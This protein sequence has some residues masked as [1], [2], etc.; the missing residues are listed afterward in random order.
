[1]RKRIVSWIAALALCLSLLPTAAWAADSFT[2]TANNTP[3]TATANS[4]DYTSEYKITEE[5]AAVSVSGSTAKG[6]ILVEASNVT[7]TLDNVSMVLSDCNGSPIE[8]AADK[9]ATL[10]LKGT[11][12]LT[13]HAAGPGI[14]VNQGA[15]LTIRAD[16]SDADASL[17]VHGAQMDQYTDSGGGITGGMM[18]G[19]AGIGGP[20]S[21]NSPLTY[22]GAINIESGTINATGYGYGAGIG[23]GDYSSGGTIHISGGKVTAICGGTDPDGW[24]S[25]THKQGSGIGASQGQASGTITISGDAVVAAYGGYA[26]AGIGGGTADVTIKDTA[27]VTAYGGTNAAG[28]GGYNQNKGDS[29]ITISDTADVTAYGGQ[30]ASGIGQGSAVSAVTLSLASTASVIAYSDGTK[31][32]IT[33]TPSNDSASIINLYMKN[34]TL[35]SMNIPL[36]LS[37]GE[38]VKQTVTLAA[39][40]KAVGTTCE[41]GDYAVSANLGQGGSYRLIPSEGTSFDVTAG[42][43]SAA[44]SGTQTV[45]LGITDNGATVQLN[46]PSGTTIFSGSG[47][48]LEFDNANGTI[49]V[50][51]GGSV[52][53]TTWPNGGTVSKSGVLSP[54]LDETF[55]FE[56]DLNA[57]EEVVLGQDLTLSVTVAP[58]ADG[59][60]LTYQWYKDGAAIQGETGASL[61]LAD[62]S[63]GDLGAYH[64]VVTKTLNGKTATLT[65][66]SCVVSTI[67]VTGITLDRSSLTLTP[68]ERAALTASLLPADAAN[69][70]I[71]WESSDE[72]VAAVD[73]NGVVSAIAAGTAIITVTTEDGGFT[74]QCEITVK[75]P[76]IPPV[77][78]S[79]PP[80]RDPEVPEEPGETGWTNPFTDVAEGAWY[81]DPVR[82]SCENGLMSGYG[83]GRFGPD[84]ILSRAQ[85]AQ[86][87]YDL[88]G[89]PAVAYTNS[90]TDVAADAWYAGAVAW[91]SASGIVDGYG[92]GRFGPN[93]PVTRE[94]LAAMLYRYA[95]TPAVGVS[96][97]ALLGRF[98]DGEAVGGWAREAVAWAVAGGLISGTDGGAL[99]P[100]GGATRAQAATILM[101]FAENWDK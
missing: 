99:A 79:V 42:A 63:E 86:I 25:S 41:A 55:A 87:L 8:I 45:L 7:V 19:F 66:Q 4:T 1:M 48:A 10:V 72:T 81:Y 47:D 17:T 68:Q 30:S 20:N 80:E 18:T 32:A 56:R 96:E 16:G 64:V 33:G 85:L 6:R 65:S 5:N 26:C 57:S 29:T 83:D 37:T 97:L 40:Y 95:G 3:V 36:T 34:V 70:N 100:R 67:R 50:P 82:Y 27:K 88:E 77:T 28:I 35:P 13:A 75:A 74:A 9:S 62:I 91:A 53:E 58:P 22:T 44:Y 69:Q 60:T 71:I 46:P 51:K 15:T 90:F 59:G 101:R 24:G 38:Q 73:Q 21:G 93:D 12:T 52:N 43:D 39:G 2:V 89:R 23:G 94:Q 11:N 78:P 84:D 49:I 54:N 14:L 61:A 92:D 31:A 76:T 98:P